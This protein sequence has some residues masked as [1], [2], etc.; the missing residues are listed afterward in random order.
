MEW[1]FREY[2]T[3]LKQTKENL[4]PK[5]I[6]VVFDVQTEEKGLDNN[7]KLQVCTSDL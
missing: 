5:D 6:V 7:L 4:S 2:R 3:P 1:E